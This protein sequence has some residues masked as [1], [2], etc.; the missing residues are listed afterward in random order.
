M[1]SNHQDRHHKLSSSNAL[2]NVHEVIE[3]CMQYMI[4]TPGD[5]QKGKKYVMGN[6]I[7]LCRYE[8]RVMPKSKWCSMYTKSRKVERYR[9]AQLQ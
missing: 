9:S 5:I 7:P 6:D 4:L 2:A 8:W 3:K 1:R